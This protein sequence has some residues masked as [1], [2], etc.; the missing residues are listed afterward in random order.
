MFGK[1]IYALIAAFFAIFNSLV[2]MIGDNV[3]D[4]PDNAFPQVAVQN[5]PLLDAVGKFQG[6][7]TD[8]EYWYFSW[9]FGLEKLDMD[10]KTVEKKLI[11]IPI[12]LLLKGYDHIGGI[13]V[14]NGLIYAPIEKGSD[15]YLQSYI[16]IYNASDLSYT[17]RLY[18][19]D[20]DLHT[21][22]VPWSA[23]DAARGL[24][25][26][27]E[28]NNAQVLNVFDL[29]T[30]EFVKTVPVSIPLHRIQDAEVWD[31]ILYC[32]AD[33]APEHTV[34]AVNPET[35]QV[36][37]VIDRFIDPANETEGF[38]VWPMPDGSVFHS[39]DTGKLSINVFFRHYAVDLDILTWD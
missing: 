37:K 28:W 22:G 39:C 26:T 25:Y 19:M 13:S 32:A 20:Y 17:G 16:A 2:I 23:A 5:F 14:A 4:M 34:W 30:L 12:N 27:A 21:E 38:T 33:N 10:F 35:G 36:Q 8:G 11:C 9:N 6:A 15:G 1:K 18:A 24:L 3:L 29:E 31:G 7:T